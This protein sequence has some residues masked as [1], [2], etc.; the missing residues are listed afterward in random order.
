[1]TEKDPLVRADSPPRAAADLF[2][3]YAP[4]LAVA[5]LPEPGHWRALWRHRELFYFLAWRDLLVRYKQTSIGI[6]W[7]AIKAI[8]TLTVLAIVF[9][10]LARL[11]SHGVPYPLMVLAAI[12]PWQFLSNALTDAGNSLV[13]SSDLVSKVYFPRL[14]IPSSAVMVNLVDLFI[15]G[16]VLAVLFVWYGFLPDIRVLALP[17]F[18]AL[19]VAIALGAGLWF[20]ALTAQYRD[21]RHILALLLQLGLYVSPVGFS[22]SII[23]E[24]WQT[25]FAL[26]PVVGVIEGFRWS[27]LRG[28][29]AA[30]L[31]ALPLSL[32][33]TTLLLV[34]GIRYYRKAERRL[35]DVI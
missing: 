12:L 23:P 14:I 4:G 18:I 19:A 9:G 30:L 3:S 31:P 28:G 10:K 27:L 7:A 13:N 25:L 24:A 33:V 8:V 6:A 32:L 29:S 16:V 34:T 26:N 5:A 35:A 2:V 15:A 22:T 21:F 17:L 11:P 20:A 1:V